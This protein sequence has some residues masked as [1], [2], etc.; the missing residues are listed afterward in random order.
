MLP[1]ASR[2]AD[3][4]PGVGLAGVLAG[5]ALQDR[6][7]TKYVLGADV[8][9]PLA[10]ALRGTHAALEID[11]LRA[12]RYRTTYFDTA[13]LRVFRDHVQRRRRRY[14]CRSREYVDTGACAFEVKLKAARGRTVKHRLAQD[15]AW[16][17][18]L[19]A[20]ALAFLDACLWRAYGR[21]PEDGLS[22]ALAVAY[23]RVTLAA[24]GLGE[25]VTLDFDLAFGAPDG[26]GGRLAADRVIVECKSRH[27]RSLA[28]RALRALGQRPEGGCSKYCLGVG[29]TRPHVPANALR[30][31]LRRHFSATPA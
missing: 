2:I 15:P 25:R 10:D 17:G 27:G 18:A 4:L 8:L 16:S 22:P 29:L 21:P 11:G 23:T 20:A 6:V 14:K 24:P 30:P 28:D 3:A 31:L 12:F 7:D 13:E 1:S 5:A 19:S 26:T 9:G